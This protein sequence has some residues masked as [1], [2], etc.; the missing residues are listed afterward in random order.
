MQDAVFA[1]LVNQIPHAYRVICMQQCHSGGFIDDLNSDRTTILTACTGTEHAHPADTEGETVNGV[2]YAHGEFNYHL[3]SALN[4]QTVTGTAVN[5]DADGNGFVT[6]REIFDYIAANESNSETPQF[7]DGSL[8]LGDRLHLSF[9]DVC[10][11]DNLDDTGIEPSTGASLC[12]SPDINH[13]RN[14]L[15]DPT[16]TLG[17]PAA[18]QQNDLFEDVEIGQNNYIYTRLRNRGYSGTPVEVDVYWTPPSTLPTP[19]S[20]NYIGTINVANVLQDTV[21]IGGPLTWPS[22]QIPNSGHYCFVAVLGNP[23]DPKPDSAAITSTSEFYDFIRNNNNVVWKNFDVENVFAGDYMQMAFLVQGWPRIPLKTDLVFDLSKLPVETKPELKLLKRLT[24]G[25]NPERL[26]KTRESRLYSHYTLDSRKEAVLKGIT[27]RPSDKSKVT[28]RLR[29]PEKTPDGEYEISVMQRVG[30][31]EM[32]FVTKLIR[33]G[34]HP[35]VVNRRRRE[36]HKA[37]CLRVRRISPRNRVA[38]RDIK[39]A[40]RHGYKACRYCRPT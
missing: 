39:L 18:W 4:G 21:T 7:D 14:Q 11:R 3:L 13:Y 5:A 31:K 25:A 2:Y 34:G 9:A 37:G 1:G 28:L 36:V 12:R 33:V 24:I 6:M 30:G 32:G 15:L 35:F 16:A 29:I 8:G 40:L 17:S 19:P 27:L 38:Y 26:E 20:W 23:Q 22:S 10:M